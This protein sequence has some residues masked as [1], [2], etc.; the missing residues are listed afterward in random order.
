LTEGSKNTNEKVFQNGT[1]KTY[2]QTN[3][4]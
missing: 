1:V 3:C 2:Y 4:K